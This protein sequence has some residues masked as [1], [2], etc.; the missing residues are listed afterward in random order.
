M[1]SDAQYIFIRAKNSNR[2]LLNFDAKV[3]DLKD[4]RIRSIPFT[5]GRPTIDE[6]KRC[7]KELL[8]QIIDKSEV[9]NLASQMENICKIQLDDLI[10]VESPREEQEKR[11][12]EEKVP[13]NDDVQLTLMLHFKRI[14]DLVR[15]GK[16]HLVK[17]QLD[18]NPSL[19]SMSDEDGNMLLHIAA[20]VDQPE[21]VKVLLEF[22]LDATSLNR[23]KQTPYQA[24]TS[25]PV[26]DVFRRFIAYN[27][28]SWDVSL[29]FIPEPLTKEME[30]RQKA[31]AKQKRTKK[32]AAD[33]PIEA[34]H[35]VEVTDEIPK[36][37]RGSLL[38]LGLSLIDSVGMSPEA[39]MKLDREKR[40]MAAEQR[41]NKKNCSHCSRDCSLNFFE[42]NFALFCSTECIKN[43]RKEQLLR[44]N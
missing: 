38:G 11:N 40:L 9:D 24:S 16:V 1:I 35:T 2:A 4:D 37:V 39:R 20:A 10:V 6:I 18:G 29:S 5:T 3:L 41:V 42:K 19:A 25:K 12:K 15:R 43:S 13:E 44:E 17:T 14:I 23:K 31:K 28:P 7:F 36:A 32:K 27:S 30:D 22:G 34:N 8:P 21:I 33:P 26:R